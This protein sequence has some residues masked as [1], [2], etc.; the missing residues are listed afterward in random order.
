MRRKAGAKPIRVAIPMLLVTAVVARP[1]WDKS[2][3]PSPRE[4]YNSQ[5]NS[6]GDSFLK[7][8]LKLLFLLLLTA[9]LSVPGQQKQDTTVESALA[10]AQ[11]AQVHNDYATAAIYYKQAI[12]FR[13]D[14]PELW[15]NLGLM[16]HETKNYADAVHSFQQALRLK[17][18]LYVPNLFLGMDYLSMGK[19]QEAISY[20]LK[21]E[22]MNGT[23]SLPPFTLGRAYASLGKFIPAAH[24]YERAIHL[25]PQKNS[26]WFGLGIARL[27]QV[28]EDARSIAG[29]EANSPYAKA[30]YA[31]SLLKQSRYKEAATTYKSILGTQPQPPCI[32]A[33]LGFVALKQQDPVSA[34]A[35]F[36]AEQ[37]T[38]PGC[39]L[40]ILGQARLQ[41]D[42]GAGSD[43]LRLLQDLWEKDQGFALSN[44]SMLTDG[45]DS[46]H[47]A[48]FQGFIV[49]QNDT[50]KISSGLYQLLSSV[51]SGQPQLPQI[52]PL[53]SEEPKSAAQKY[54]LS[55]NYAQCANS[56]K[57]SLITKNVSDLQMLAA[58]SYFT[59]EYELTANASEELAAI[60]P[61]SIQ[62]LYWSIKAN[63]HL[64]FIALDKFQQLEPNSARS[65]L[66]LGDIYRQRRRFDDAQS[67]YQKA[68]AITPNDSAALLGMASAYFGDDNIE[69]TIQTARIALG[70]TPNDPELNLLMGE[71][72]VSNNQ[73]TDAEP[74]LLKALDAKPQTL[75]HV[76]ALLGEVYAGT[77]KTAQALEQLKLGLSSDEDGSLHYQIA[78]IYRKMGDAKNAAIAIDEMK[79]LQQQ[80]RQRAVIALQDAHSSDLDGP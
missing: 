78:R 79:V 43:A 51:F 3:I 22:K 47:A 36:D 44:A 75:P 62:A 76:H 28:E 77:D 18:S 38:D 21:A 66:L 63:E 8:C 57:N 34:E 45:I 5:G 2:L 37:K 58:C 9:P 65:H 73:L 14:I 17:P 30:L 26:A 24:A 72:L 10:A 33:E 32:H 40:A 39:S 70:Q 67:E 12:K 16:Q 59:G 74:F 15:A 49:K 19:A 64:A 54:Y 7:L 1:H 53:P 69:K 71:A 6:I 42:A 29:E 48:A 31:E 68:L 11:Q 56:V 80:R 20:L 13:P 60:R 55:G 50:G 52:S 61:H 35:E 25:D 23:D 46:A 4:L 27:D 41:I